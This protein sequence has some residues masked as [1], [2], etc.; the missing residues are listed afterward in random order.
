MTVE[1]ETAHI[2]AKGMIG[3]E[4]TT[5]TD[6]MT[7]IEETTATVTEDETTTADEMTIATQP[8]LHHQFP[9]QYKQRDAKQQ[10]TNATPR[11]HPL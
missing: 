11:A 5:A 6:E 9:H 8:A 2:A 3:I 10:Q 1:A 4:G 7:G